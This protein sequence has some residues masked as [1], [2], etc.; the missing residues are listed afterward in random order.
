MAS[1]STSPAADPRDNV[2]RIKRPLP[3]GS[4]LFAGIRAADALLQ[5]GLVA[6]SLASPGLRAIVKDQQT[7]W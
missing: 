5:Y 3:L 4:T 7:H 1:S 2:S 6:Y